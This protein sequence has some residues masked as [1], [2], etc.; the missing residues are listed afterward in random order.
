MP[1]PN[2]AAYLFD[3]DSTLSDPASRA[4]M[5][6]GN[7]T[8]AEWNAF[9]LAA[10]N[11]TPIESTV[12]IAKA[13]QKDYKIVILTG[14]SEVAR[15]ITIAWLKKH[16]IEYDELIMRQVNDTSDHV[17]FKKEAYMKE[18]KPKYTV[19]GSFDD[20]SA[21]AY[22]WSTLGITSYKQINP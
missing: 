15:D 13:L 4:D 18:V 19:L 17:I 11:D 1:I 5:L 12:L 22:M 6:S 21:I 8:D 14:R 9:F 7:P 2:N 10:G 3:M 16:G 20:N